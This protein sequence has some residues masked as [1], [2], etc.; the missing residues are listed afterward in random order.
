[1]FRSEVLQT[2]LFRDTKISM[3]EEPS[4]GQKQKLALARALYRDSYVLF[5]D[6]PTSAIDADSEIRI[7]KALDELPADKTVFF[8]SHD[9]S[10]IRRADRILVFD[11]G[12]IIEDGSHEE[13]LAKGG[14][15]SNLYN[16]QKEAYE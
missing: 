12:Q 2:T 3:N 1:M 5:L 10:T 4:K 14:Q 6:E 7:F 8:I 9:F 15:Y 16:K 13:L 11:Q